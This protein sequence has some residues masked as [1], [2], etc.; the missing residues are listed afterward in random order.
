MAV[1]HDGK[2]FD[3]GLAQARP[4]PRPN[5]W[6]LVK[7]LLEYLPLINMY[8]AGACAGN[9]GAVLAFDPAF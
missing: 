6:P 2:W 4:P 8:V 7:E 1:A 9:P 5:R 3:A